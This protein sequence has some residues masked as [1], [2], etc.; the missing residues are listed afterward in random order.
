MA[1]IAWMSAAELGAAYRAGDL[2]PRQVA[3]QLLAR[4]KQ[5][6]GDIN[7]FCLVDEGETQ[8][9][10]DEATARYAAGNPL[11]PLDGVPVGI[12]DL[13]LTAG[14]PTLRGS[15]TVDPNGP[16]DMDAPAVARLKE[17]GAIL[18]GKTTMPEFG[19]KGTNDNPLTGITRN[20]W[21]LERTP[22]ASS[23][24]S[25]AALAAGLCPLATGTDGGGS[26]RIPAAFSGVSGLK[27]SYGR[28]PA[29][30]LSPFGTVAHVGPMARTVEDLGLFL[31]EIAKP[32]ARDWYHL[33]DAGIDWHKAATAPLPDDARLMV[34]ADLGYVALHPGRAGAFGEAG[35]GLEGQVATLVV[36]PKLFDDPVDL[37]K[38]LWYGGAAFLLEDLPEDRFAMI[39]PGLQW[40]V[41]QGRQISR[42]EFQ[43][44]VKARETFGSEMRQMMEGFH[45]LLTPQMPI[46]AFEVG[47]NYPGGPDN[48]KPGGGTWEAWTPF[49]Y[50][51]NLTQQPAATV[52]CGFSGDGLPL[53]L[54]IVAPQFR[55]DLALAV[56]G[57]YQRATDWH[58][59]HPALY[60]S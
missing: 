28:V 59:H 57:V 50:P 5:F 11:G 19:W 52:P 8:R 33:P 27:P 10:A 43:L 34:S 36:A 13:L 47:A 16:W 48:S 12:K 21:N 55:D 40:V 38:T 7:C 30:P 17:A 51:F 42:R 37:F 46:P 26:I 18:I 54:Q 60:C 6:D 32:D 31:K 20:P 4:I 35:K 58:R 49:T 29:F 22:G 9:Q 2:T 23:G 3:D 56:A 39:D 24:G 14:W 41:E 25:G 53:A 45:G 44:A 1:D 15:K